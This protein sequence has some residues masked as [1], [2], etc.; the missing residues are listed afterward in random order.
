MP[1]S[2][3]DQSAASITSCFK[4]VELIGR[5]GLSYTTEG[6]GLKT[7]S[8]DTTHNSVCQTIAKLQLYQISTNQL[9]VSLPVLK[10]R[11]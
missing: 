2:N 7:K 11:S 1:E 10:R 8:D 6:Q 3:I 9:R 4:G 5:A